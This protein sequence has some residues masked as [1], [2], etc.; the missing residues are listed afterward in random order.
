MEEK[1]KQTPNR[2][3]ELREKLGLSQKQVVHRVRGIDQPRLA[4]YEAGSQIPPLSHALRLAFFYQEPIQKLFPAM[5]EAARSD[6]LENPISVR[7]FRRRIYRA[8]EGST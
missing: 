7:S 1:Q 6:I 3:R 5:F 8:R 4:R 2:L